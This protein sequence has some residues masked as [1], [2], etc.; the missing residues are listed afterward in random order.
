[1]SV[2]K[3]V[4]GD[5]NLITDRLKT[6]DERQALNQINSLKSQRNN[7]ILERPHDVVE[8]AILS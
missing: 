1:M 3:L 4:G 2:S 7:E 5:I 8:G 6:R